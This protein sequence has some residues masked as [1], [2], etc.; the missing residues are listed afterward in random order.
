[1]VIPQ[2]VQLTLI[3]LGEITFKLKKRLF[4]FTWEIYYVSIVPWEAN[5]RY[6][7]DDDGVRDRHYRT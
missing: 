5:S 3:D 6:Q 7:H 1:M 2:G 4:N